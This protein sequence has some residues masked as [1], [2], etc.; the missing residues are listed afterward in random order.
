[1]SFADV[2]VDAPVEPGRTFTY[3]IPPHLPVQPGQLVWAPFGRRTVQGI[4]IALSGNSP[5][6]ATR[7]L[8]QTV[9]PSPLLDAPRL[10]LA[11]WLSR[12]YRCSLFAACT[13]LLPPGFETQVRSR[14]FP[15]PGLTAILANAIDADVDAIPANAIPSADAAVD[16]AEYTPGDAV[17]QSDAAIDAAEY[18]AANTPGDA[19]PAADAA[20]DAAEYAALANTPGDAIPPADAAADT[21]GD[22]ITDAAV[23]AAEYV[24]LANTPGDAVLHVDAAVDAAE[25]AALANTP[26]DAIQSADAVD[27]A[28]YADADT[29]GDA[30]PPAD[31]ALAAAGHPTST[32]PA[33][34]TGGSPPALRPETA[35]ALAALAA[36][37]SLAESEF[38]KLLGRG[39]QRE[40]PRL[41]EQGL[42]RRDVTLPRPR[43]APRYEA[44]LLPLPRYDG[45]GDADGGISGGDDAGADAAGPIPANLKSAKQRGLLAAVL[46]AQPE[47]YPVTLANKLFGSGAAAAL[48]RRGL[49]GMEWLRTGGGPPSPPPEPPPGQLT[50]TP[51]Q[52]RAL[53]AVTAALSHPPE[54]ASRRP[55]PASFLLYGVTGSGKTEVYLR[56]IEAALRQGRQAIFLVPEISLTPQTM[57][58]VNARFGG[59]AAL[60]HSRQTPRQQFDQWWEIRGGRYELVV[61]PR[62]ALF[63]P[64]E[65]LGLIVIDEE[66]EWTYKQHETHPLYHARTAALELARQ[67]G[68]V[69]LLG[70]ATP[71]VETFHRAI[72][73]RDISTIAD[74][75][76]A[77]ANRPPVSRPVHPPAAAPAAPGSYRIPPTPGHPAGAAAP[78]AVNDAPLTIASPNTAPPTP[79]SG[80]S[81]PAIPPASP[82][83]APAATPG[84]NSAEFPEAPPPAGRHRLLHLPYRVSGGEL[85]RV[86]ICDM[87]QELRQGNR[88]IFSRALSSAL[89]D[90]IGGGHQALL[91]LNRRGAASIVQ[92]R[93]CGY[94]AACRSCQSPYTYHQAIGRLVCHH[95][96]RRRRLPAACPQCRSRHIRQ[97]GA[98]TERVV[99]EVRRLLPGARVERLDADAAQS[100]ETGAEPGTGGG[101][102]GPAPAL[103]RLA[104]GETQVL[105]GTQM[106]TKGLDVPNLTLVGI[107]LADIGL[108]RPD[109]R[110]GER[111]FGL[112]C[113][114]AGRAGRGTAP[115]RVII[116]TYSPDHYAVRAAA[117]QDYA[118]LYRT[119]LAARRQLGYPPFNQLA[120]LVYQH[121]DPAAC[122]SQAAAAAAELRRRAA[123]AG[124][125]DI[126]VSGPAP[127]IPE[128]LRGRHRWRLL[129]RGQ[130]L[131]DFL[132]GMNF[133]PS[134]TIDIDPV[135][136]L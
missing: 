36:K 32:A 39:G 99:D 136:T 96:N 5:V 70:S 116:Q 65:N 93:D 53:T 37:P 100:P 112:L 17:P 29:P 20:V 4:V 132:Q 63:A 77:A 69:V 38:V 73:G 43:I 84:G 89:S 40:L 90:C 21:S 125:T 68:A 81:R 11:Q 135:H 86:E 92:C 1:M 103:E 91:F 109:F 115:G 57:E 113:Q 110:A 75:P 14:I 121:L 133:P 9:E 62:S 74:R 124:R 61:G 27:A 41:L 30:I 2:A 42:L 80:D 101:R 88:H 111:A 50:L 87:R 79:S 35:A 76:P 55:A 128:R 134:C 78:Q 3:R 71:D 26:G 24:A 33:K 64:L 31:A 52:E 19:I 114:V 105:V 46:A 117:A 129:L 106:V 66:H 94:A 118:A 82:N 56:S 107:V 108:Y 123:A 95:C 102:P 23:D 47:P 45:G 49:V 7:D 85:A 12:Y 83:L 126:A 25:Y 34:A 131:P 51:E 127:G 16:A 98:G 18:A 54:S 130:R 60:L 67:T 22:A 13:P 104:S 28:E 122:Q 15:A 72:P 6:A 8:L 59:R 119:E 97:L 120:H 44:R 48:F 58:R 10:E